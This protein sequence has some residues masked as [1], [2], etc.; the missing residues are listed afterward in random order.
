MMLGHSSKVMAVASIT[1]ALASGLRTD[2]V[3]SN[4]AKVPAGW[5]HHGGR[6]RGGMTN[7]SQIQQLD[8]IEQAKQEDPF[9]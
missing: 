8:I 3:M 7:L 9:D 2:L 6:N 1:A 5:K 4:L